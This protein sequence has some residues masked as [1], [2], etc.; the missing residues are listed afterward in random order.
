MKK[1][2]KPKLHTITAKQ[3]PKTMKNKFTLPNIVFTE[4]SNI[5]NSKKAKENKDDSSSFLSEI[6]I[7]SLH[8]QSIDI[9][10]DDDS[11]DL[12]SNNIC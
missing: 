9:S 8:T 1:Q 4:N 10:S 5:N 7:Y 12:T 11:F 6:S 3:K 2:I